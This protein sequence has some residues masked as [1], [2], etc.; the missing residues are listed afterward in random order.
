MPG[1]RQQY[2]TK[3]PATVKKLKYIKLTRSLRSG[4]ARTVRYTKSLLEQVAGVGEAVRRQGERKRSR[5]PYSS[6]LLLFAAVLAALFI[7]LNSQD[8]VVERVLV[9]IPGLNSDLEGYTILHI[10]D[11]HG[12]SFGAKQSAI[13]SALSGY[14]YQVVILSG[15]MVGS[16]G[17]AQPLYDLLGG[18]HQKRPVYF[19]AGDSDP[20]PLLDVPRDVLGN[21][22]KYVLADWILGAEELGA[23]YL[24]APVS[25]KIGSATIWLSPTDQLFL[26]AEVELK[27]ASYAVKIEEDD[28]REGIPDAYITLPFTA[29]RQLSLQALSGAIRVMNNDDVHI[30]VS[31]YPPTY[32][33]IEAINRKSEMNKEDEPQYMRAVDLALAGHYCGGVWK[34]PFYGALFIPS[35]NAERHGWLPAQEDVDGLKA[36]GNSFIFINSG[37]AVT[38]KIFLPEIR[39]FNNP[40]ITL[41]T[42]T[43]TLTDDLL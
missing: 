40:K 25:L 33:Q 24:N 28:V 42:L 16:G 43:G 29:Y 15:D 36:V 30:A 19:V 17:N 38:D 22:G 26:N 21:L 12:A 34:L 18:L 8:I 27:R 31:H 41:L 37:L 13:I 14:S 35:I 20:N 7:S 5:I 9:S 1:K 23:H 11:M 4:R 39:L 6:L 10:S 2:F 3:H 32:E